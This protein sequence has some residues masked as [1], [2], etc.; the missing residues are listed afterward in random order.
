MSLQEKE[1]SDQPLVTWG[2]R[3]KPMM[4]QPAGSDVWVQVVVVQ[5]REDQ[6]LVRYTG[7]RRPC[8]C[9]ASVNTEHPYTQRLTLITI[10]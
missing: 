6:I 10:T 7:A 2:K 3:H 1:T 4:E 8:N 9:T 5:T